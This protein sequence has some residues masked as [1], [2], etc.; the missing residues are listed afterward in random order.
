MTRFLLD[1]EI[2]NQIFDELPH[3]NEL[4]ATV[5]KLAPDFISARFNPESNVPVAAVCLRDTLNV[6]LQ[7]RI[8]LSE[9]LQHRVWYREI[10]D[11]PSEELAVIFMQ[12]YIDGVVSRLYA[13]GEHLANAIIFMLEI[14]D[15]QLMG[16]RNNRVS[17]QSIVGHY[18]AN[19]LTEHPVTLATL[20]LASS[21]EWGKTIEYRNYWVHEQPPTVSGLG[22][23]YQREKRWVTSDDGTSIKLGLGSGDEAEYTVDEL[24]DFV[25]PAAFR[26]VYLYEE[27]VRFYVNLISEQGINLT[28]DGIQLR[29]R[30]RTP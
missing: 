19:E 21:D 25:Q 13:A 1:D 7:I 10:S 22:N 18:L 6:L 17:Q 11:T 30:R 20:S 8:G 23:V 15:E 9:C 26:F 3:I 28:E 2:L 24:L 16:Y 27:V 14:S 5:N 12:F 4:G 29:F